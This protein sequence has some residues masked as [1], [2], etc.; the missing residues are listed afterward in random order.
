MTAADVCAVIYSG[1]SDPEVLSAVRGQSRRPRVV[2]DY[3]PSLVAAVRAAQSCETAW[4][5]LLDGLAVPHGDALEAL[6]S[7]VRTAP[8]APVLVTSKVVGGHGRL[9]PDATPRHEILATEH[10]IRAA[11]R[12]L[13]E[14]RTAAPGSVLADRLTLQWFRLPRPDLPPG[15]DML[16][17]SARLLRG[18]D[19]VGYLVTG[20]VAVRALPPG[21]ERHFTARVRLLASGAWSPKEKFRE[22]LLLGSD[23]AAA[24]R[25]RR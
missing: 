15:L 4:V 21:S 14:L 22:G 17:W 6:L 3:Q 18:P 23:A 19:R 25:N 5:W 1:D 16:E 12:H 9:H 20:S 7:A 13:V 2:L 24:I 8:R 11:E 10:S